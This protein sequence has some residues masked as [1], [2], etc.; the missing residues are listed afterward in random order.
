V[1]AASATVEAGEA[2]DEA[3]EADEVEEDRDLVSV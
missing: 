2:S 3:D 1:P